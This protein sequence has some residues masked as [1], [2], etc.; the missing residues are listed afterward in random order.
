MDKIRGMVFDFDGT[1]AELN[2]DFD[3]MKRKLAALAE[4]FLGDRPEPGALPALEW[5]EVLATKI[6][7]ANRDEGLEFHCRGRLAIAAMEL[8][9][10]RQ[11]RL[12]PFTRP[13]LL[14]LRERGVRTGIITR[15]SYAAVKVVFPDIEQ[16]C[17]VF[18]AREDAIRVKPHGDH[19]LQALMAMGVPPEHGLMVGDHPMDV[20]TARNG[21]TRAAGVLSGRMTEA[22]FSLQQPDFMDRDAQALVRSL[23][24]IELL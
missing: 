7:E 10:A 4:V 3:L 21:G 13:L 6:G 17:D 5:M 8:D 2:L 11:G 16:G 24:H 18:I 15:N 9:A 12:F 1:L 14:E 19:L 22:D 20:T 23:V